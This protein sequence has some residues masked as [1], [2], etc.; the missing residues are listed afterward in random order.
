MNVC[1]RELEKGNITT[2]F[3]YVNYA[4]FTENAEKVESPRSAIR[5]TIYVDGKEQ[6]SSGNAAELE[7]LVT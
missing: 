5:F 7:R 3:L 2:P 1:A 4:N 6:A